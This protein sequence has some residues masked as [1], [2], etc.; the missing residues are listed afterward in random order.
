MDIFYSSVYASGNSS[1]LK[2]KNKVFW[3]GK[4]KLSS[5]N[6]KAIFSIQFRYNF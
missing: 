4:A 1:L 6:V 3:K 2:E 5:S